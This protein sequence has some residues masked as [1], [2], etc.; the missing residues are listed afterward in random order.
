MAATEASNAAAS[1][2]CNCGLDAPRIHDGTWIVL[3]AV[4]VWRRNSRAV[5]A[6]RCVEVERR[7][8]SRVCRD[9]RSRA[10]C[11]CGADAFPLARAKTE[12]HARWKRLSD[13]ARDSIAWCPVGG[14]SPRAC[15][16]CGVG[17]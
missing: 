9:Y 12:I 8:R 11:Y 10:E 4:C 5:D 1:H 16:G 15:H 7:A 13:S 2:A 17:A 6:D 14:G 3:R